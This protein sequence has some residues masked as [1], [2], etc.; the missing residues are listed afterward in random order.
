MV[1]CD[2][3]RKNHNYEQDLR[4]PPIMLLLTFVF[5]SENTDNNLIHQLYVS[6]V[7]WYD[8]LQFV[9]E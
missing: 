3:N 6:L 2:E 7:A 9:A 8:R 5:T 1:V 4:K